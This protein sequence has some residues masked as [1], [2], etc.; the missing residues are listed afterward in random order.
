M[1]PAALF[2]IAKSNPNV[3]QQMNKQNMITRTMI[4]QYDSALKRKG[5]LS[6]ET[7][8]MD[9]DDSTLSKIRH[10]K[11][12]AYDSI[13]VRLSKIGKCTETEHRMGLTGG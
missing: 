4:I 10:K 7:T 11:L 1:F 6:H 5:I 8:W 12:N 3:Y 2:T 13:H 9:P